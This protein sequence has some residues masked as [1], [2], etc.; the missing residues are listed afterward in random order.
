MEAAPH[1]HPRMLVQVG[2]NLVEEDIQGQLNKT[3]GGRRYFD[4]VQRH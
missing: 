3:A 2:H 1:T 4:G